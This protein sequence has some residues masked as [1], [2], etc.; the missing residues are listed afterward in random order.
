LASQFVSR[1]HATLVQILNE[2]GTFHYRLVDGVPKGK[3]SSNGVMVNGR[4]VL[5]CDLKDQDEISFGPQVRAVYHL[6]EQDISRPKGFDET[7]IPSEYWDEIEI[8]ATR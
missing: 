5:A 3:P 1:R 8:G 4:K 7:L 6:Y 2:D